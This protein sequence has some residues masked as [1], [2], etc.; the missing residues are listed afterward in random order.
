MAYEVGNAPERKCPGKGGIWL[1]GPRGRPVRR[2]SG[3]LGEFRDGF[4][5]WM[6]H[7]TQGNGDQ[8][9]VAALHGR[10]R[11][12]M[13]ISADCH[14]GLEPPT[15]S[16]GHVVYGINNDDETPGG[17]DLYR[18]RL[19]KHGACQEAFAKPTRMAIP[20]FITVEYTIDGN[21][22]FYADN[23]PWGRAF[24][25]RGIFQ[26]DPARVRWRRDCSLTR[27]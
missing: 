16:H 8:I 25:S 23:P 11:T 19:R 27:W 2:G 3:R 14:C 13:R 10:V 7:W 21:D 5:T 4:A 24:G 26:I 9:R 20:A 17:V 12:L 22:I 1:R 6:A 18:L 15:I